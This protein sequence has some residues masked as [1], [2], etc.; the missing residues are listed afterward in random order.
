[1]AG[2]SFDFRPV[3]LFYNTCAKWCLSVSL[4]HSLLSPSVERIQSF[5]MA[6]VF[7]SVCASRPHHPL[8]KGNDTCCPCVTHSNPHFAL[9]FGSPLSHHLSSMMVRQPECGLHH[10]FLFGRCRGH[11][12]VLEVTTLKRFFAG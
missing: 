4:R 3:F 8:C 9:D 11:H 6:Q 12:D 1:M 5:H 2:P 10:N 7:S